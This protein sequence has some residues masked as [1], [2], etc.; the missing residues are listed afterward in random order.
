MKNALFLV[1]LLVSGSVNSQINIQDK[2]T[3]TTTSIGLFG[4]K[5]T[6]GKEITDEILDK[7]EPGKTTYDD[8]IKELGK[9]TTE[10]LIK[11][12]QMNMIIVSYVSAKSEV[13]TN[14]IVLGAIPLIGGLASTLAGRTEVQAEQ[15]SVGFIFNADT[16]LLFGVQNNKADGQARERTGMERLSDA[17]ISIGKPP[18]SQTQSLVSPVQQVLAISNGD[19]IQPKIPGVKIL[20]GA[21]QNAKQTGALKKDEQVVY[22]GEESNG[23]VKIQGS[24]GEGW[25]DKRMMKK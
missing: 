9:P 19:V 25:V 5:A 16:K 23:F 4:A 13:D 22:L 7:F 1:L 12:R 15:Q 18:E 20:E 2:G 14:R 21:N 24:D 10:R 8:V 11:N 3:G 6:V 17:S